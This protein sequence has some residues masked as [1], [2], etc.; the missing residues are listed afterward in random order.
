M[1]NYTKMLILHKLTFIANI[2]SEKVKY[3][4]LSQM[5]SYFLERAKKAT[6]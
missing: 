5:I 2:S 6:S 3:Y 1:Y 4:N